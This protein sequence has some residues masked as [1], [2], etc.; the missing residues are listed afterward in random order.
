MKKRINPFLALDYFDFRLFFFGSFISQMGTQMQVVAVSWELYQLTHSA[1]SLGLLGLSEFIPV[2]LFAL[3]GGIAADKFNRKKI[4]IF[5]QIGLAIM[6]GV[7]SIASIEGITSPLLIYIVMAVSGVGMAFNMP[8]RQ[9]VLPH[10]VPRKYFMN[11]VSLNT[12]QRQTAIIVGPA[13]AGFMIALYGVETIYIFNAITFLILIMTLLPI[14][15]PAHE[16]KADFDW[17]SVMHG[18]KFV[19]S[20]QVLYSTMILDFLATFFGTATILMPIF[21]ADIFHTGAKGL[22]LLY[23]A[24]AVG[25]VIAGLIMSSIHRVRRQGVII[26]G[27]IVLYGLATVGFGL[28]TSF[29]LALFFLALTGAGDMISTILRNTIRQL[30]TPD[31]LRGRMVSINMIFVQGGPKLGET[32]A[33]LLAAMVGAP[34]SVVIGGVGTVAIALLL[35]LIMPK[36][37]KFQGHELAV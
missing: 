4:L 27:S 6:A 14:K 26:I 18:L 21:A 10:L 7:L 17:K 3:V 34:V 35:A 11:A 22:G 25:G 2:I 13:V 12:L 23:S 36:L 9:G 8:A 5:S 33:G 20:N 30:V 24:P 29:A 37:R 16:K 1:S 32:E 19:K 28:T 31:H 15:I